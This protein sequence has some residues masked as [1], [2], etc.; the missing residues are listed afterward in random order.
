M[1][2]SKRQLRRIIN[3][4]F[5]EDPPQ[6]TYTVTVTTTFPKALIAD[7]KHGFEPEEWE[8]TEELEQAVKEWMRQ[9]LQDFKD[10]N[11]AAF[12]GKQGRDE[13]RRVEAV[14]EATYAA[15]QQVK[16]TLGTV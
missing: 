16:A 10:G 5:V 7:A 9:A 4:V 11:S 13:L 1:K 3:E 12:K 15:A 6:D 14:E 8:I 2:I